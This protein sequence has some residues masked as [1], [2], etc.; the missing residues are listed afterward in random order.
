[1]NKTIEISILSLIIGL[2]IIGGVKLTDNDIYFC[3][4]RNIVMECSR[5]SES[6]LRCY[7]NLLNNSG[8]RD[9]KEGWQEVVEEIGIQ[10][11]TYSISSTDYI[12]SHNGCI[13]G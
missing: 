10:Q 4:S 6:G 7:P 2:T 5:F 13:L 9:C 1:M 11:K 3:E 8:Y 12:C